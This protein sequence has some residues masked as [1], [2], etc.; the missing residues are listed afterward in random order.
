MNKYISLAFFIIVV[1]SVGL[2]IGYS[3]AP[4]AW[5]HSLEKPPF[6]PP[7]WLFAPAWTLIYVLIAIAGWRVMMI[8]GLSGWSGRVWFVQMALNYAWS[9]VF[10]GLQMPFAALAMIVL[11]LFSI[12]AFLLLARDDKARWCFVPYA[13]WVAFAT[14]LNGWIAFAN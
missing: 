3:T 2:L 1:V 4:G 11:L 12:I 6:N 5:Y 9:P 10:F 14:V 7:N 13:A 8:E